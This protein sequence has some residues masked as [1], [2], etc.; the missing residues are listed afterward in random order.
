M[1]S[2]IKSARCKDREG[3]FVSFF[4]F[5]LFLDTAAIG[6]KLVI[7]SGR[8]PVSGS[9]DFTM[10]AL[11]PLWPPLVQI[12]FWTVRPSRTNHSSPVEEKILLK[13]LI[14]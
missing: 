7:T 12:N 8:K 1:S 5:S 2:L 10:D 6:S 9:N 14:N 4:F 3:I 13:A 11:A